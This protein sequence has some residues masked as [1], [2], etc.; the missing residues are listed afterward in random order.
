M[1]QFASTGT[2]S[3]SV[4]IWSC[5]TL[6]T[7]CIGPNTAEEDASWA[8]NGCSAK[9]GKLKGALGVADASTAAFNLESLG[10]VNHLYRHTG[11]G[12]NKQS[13]CQSIHEMWG[14]WISAEEQCSLFLG[15]NIQLISLFSGGHTSVPLSDSCSAST[16]GSFIM[17]DVL[18]IT[19]H[20]VFRVPWWRAASHIYKRL[21]VH[22]KLQVYHGQRA[23]TANKW[24]YS[25]SETH[26]RQ[27]IVYLSQGLYGCQ[28]LID[29]I[30]TT[31]MVQIREMNTCI[32]CQLPSE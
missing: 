16:V 23:G 10:G 9:L 32:F 25:V 22:T 4:G 30:F 29:P 28:L 2:T 14:G 11:K 19:H 15:G 5:R 1:L 17:Q 31:G 27:K 18:I 21:R 26:A 20:H 13:F 8:K 24:I 3:R 7:I 12:P 6:F